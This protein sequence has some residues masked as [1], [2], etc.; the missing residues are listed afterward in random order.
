MTDETVRFL[1]DLNLP[2]MAACW[3]SLEE[4]HRL[5]KVSLRD[6]MQLM[7]RIPAIPV[8]QFR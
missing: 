4:T 1:H 8:H 2:G 3:T 7:L 6:G 5:D